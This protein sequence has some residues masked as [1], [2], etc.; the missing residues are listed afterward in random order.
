MPYEQATKILSIQ[1]EAI[2]KKLEA[3]EVRTYH[4]MVKFKIFVRKLVKAVYVFQKILDYLK[5]KSSTWVLI[6]GNY[7]ILTPT[8]I[9]PAGQII[10]KNIGMKQ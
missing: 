4:P 3:Q 6:Q 1:L 2:A 9:I 5:I 10:K 7:E 8:T